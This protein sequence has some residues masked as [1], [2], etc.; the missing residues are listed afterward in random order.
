MVDV[1]RP[2]HARFPDFARTQLTATCT[3]AP[4]ESVYLPCGWFHQVESLSDSIS[5]TWN[6]V[7]AASAASLRTWLEGPISDFDQSVL[8]LF[9]RCEPGRGRHGPGH[10]AARR[11]DFHSRAPA[12]ACPRGVCADF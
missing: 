12:R 8:R 2:D 3:L 7:H 6:F 5:L 9:L 1:T 10:R 11:G 4:G